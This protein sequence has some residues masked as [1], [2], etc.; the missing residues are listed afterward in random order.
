MMFTQLT[1]QQ[2]TFVVHTGWAVKTGVVL[3]LS[4]EPWRR[5][6][7]HLSGTREILGSIPSGGEKFHRG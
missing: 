6:L 1:S 3:V 5:W 2:T 7:R 4:N